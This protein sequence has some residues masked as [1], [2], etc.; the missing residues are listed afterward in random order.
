MGEL[1]RTQERERAERYLGVYT[2]LGL[3]SVAHEVGALELTWKAGKGVSEACVSPRCKAAATISSSLILARSRGRISMTSP[4]KPATDTSA[5]G[6]T[7][8]LSPLPPGP[9]IWR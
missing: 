4:R 8:S 7:V 6:P 9:P 1:R 2:V 5:S 3:R